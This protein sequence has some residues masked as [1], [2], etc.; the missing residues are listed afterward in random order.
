MGTNF[1]QV[2]FFLLPYLLKRAFQ[3]G[4]GSVNRIETGILRESQFQK[5]VHKIHQRI[6]RIKVFSRIPPHG[7]PL[8]KIFG[9]NQRI[10]YKDP[11]KDTIRGTIYLNKK[12]R[13]YASNQDIFNLETP[14]R[15]YKF[16]CKKNDMAL[17]V[18]AIKDCIKNYGKDE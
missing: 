14:K 13:V 18:S 16:K 2:I 7:L 11:D 10:T 9:E 12:C 3:Q 15:D 17:W 4:R 6:S 5:V 8:L 1:I